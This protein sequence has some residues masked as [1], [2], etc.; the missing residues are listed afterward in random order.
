VVLDG[1]TVRG[2]V[3]ADLGFSAEE[4]AENIRRIGEMA[5]LLAASGLLVLVA[6]ISPIAAERERA[7]RRAGGAFRE[8]FVNAGLASCEA[9]DVKGLYARARRGEIAEFTGV[10]APYEPPASP[11]LELATDRLGEGEAAGRLLDF[12][13]REFAVEREPLSV[14]S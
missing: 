5:A 7:R 6:C 4:R 14:A 1:D 11:D 9:R 12:I 3:N 13:Q 8:V 10:S 2:T